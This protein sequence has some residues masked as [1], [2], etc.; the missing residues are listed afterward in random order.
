MLP[1]LTISIAKQTHSQC[2]ES[3]SAFSSDRTTSSNHTQVLNQHEESLRL[4]EW[5]WPIKGWFT[6][7]GNCHLFTLKVYEFLSCVEHKRRYFEECCYLVSKQLLVAID[8]HSIYFFIFYLLW[9]SVATSNCLV[10]NILQ[11]IFLCFC[12]FFCTELKDLYQILVWMCVLLP[13]IWINP[14]SNFYCFT[15]LFKTGTGLQLLPNPL[16]YPLYNIVCS[17]R[18]VE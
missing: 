18:W 16:S 7:K 12:A 8:F 4:A 13:L 1:D 14:A 17:V 11:N 9:K 2:N 6:Q 15:S 10:T 5:A 3:L